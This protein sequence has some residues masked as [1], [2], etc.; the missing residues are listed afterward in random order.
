MPR[1]I[2]IWQ[3]QIAISMQSI[4]KLVIEPV[5]LCK[6]YYNPIS[7]GCAFYDTHLI[8]TYFGLPIA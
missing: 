1:R 3:R 4:P 6:S 5:D 8:A 2:K 7:L